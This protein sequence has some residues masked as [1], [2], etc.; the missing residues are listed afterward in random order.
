MKKKY[1]LDRKDGHFVK[2]QSPF[3]RLFNTISPRRCDNIVYFRQ[4][5]DVENIIKY[6]D[7]NKKKVSMLHILTAAIAKTVNKQDRKSVV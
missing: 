6:I 1:K 3:S 7:I 5:I 2:E 4:T